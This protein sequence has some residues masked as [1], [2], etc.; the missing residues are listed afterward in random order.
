[1]CGVIRCYSVAWLLKDG[2]VNDHALP[3][4]DADV[5]VPTRGDTEFLWGAG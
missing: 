1:V 2:A 4:A 5:L 3:R